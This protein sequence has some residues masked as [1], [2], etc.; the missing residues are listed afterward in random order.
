MIEAE[1]YEVQEDTEFEVSWL[2]RARGFR[3]TD[4]SLIGDGLQLTLSPVVAGQ[5]NAIASPAVSAPPSTNH[6]KP[7]SKAILKVRSSRC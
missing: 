1:E 6:T 7:C 5:L 2:V 3:P 4:V